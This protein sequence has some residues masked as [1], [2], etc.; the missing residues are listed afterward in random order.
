MPN[1]HQSTIELKLIQWYT[2]LVNGR[3]FKIKNLYVESLGKLYADTPKAV[4]AAI[5]YS[6]A[7]ALSNGPQNASSIQKEILKEW[8]ILYRNGIIAQKPPK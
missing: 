3:G 4:F 6:L 8:D 1:K 5:A 7:N 2:A